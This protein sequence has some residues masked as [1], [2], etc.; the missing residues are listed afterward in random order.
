MICIRCGNDNAVSFRFCSNCGTELGQTCPTCGFEN[1][2]ESKFCGCCGARLQEI[3]GEDAQGERRQLTVLFCDIVGATA[4]SQLLDPE[5]LRE[6]I[7]S[8]QKVCGDAVLA[9]EGHVAQYLGD[10]V[11]MYF[12]Y[13]RSH[14]DEA[15]RA[16]RCGLDILKGVDAVRESGRIL[17]DT[18]LDVRLG[19]HTGRVVVGPVGDR[20]DQIALGDTPNIAARIQSEAEPGTLVV[21]EVTWRIVEGYVTG[22]C[23]G[24]WQL[25]GVSEPMRLWLVTGES[26]SRE[27]V[28]VASMLTSFVGREQERS[29]LGQ[30]WDDSRAGHNRFVLLRGDPG[31]GK[32]R[33]AQLFCEEVQFQ[34]ADLLSMR[35]TPYNTNSPFHPVIELIERRFGL[36]HGQTPTERLERIEEGLA[37]LELA[38]PEAIALLAS[39]L[40]IP[41]GNRYAPL[42]LSPA[43]RRTR[44]MQLLAD[45]IIAITRAGPVLLLVE[46]LH[47]T[48][49]STLEFLQLLVTT[50]A[51]VPLLG[52]FTA[53]CE[54]DVCWDAT[55]AVHR[56]ELPRF[57][58]AEVETMVRSVALGKAL[59]S[60]VLW[61]ITVRS[62]GVP[63]FVEELT[64][65]ILDSGALSERAVSWEA[66]GPVAIEIPA[67]MDASLTSRIDRLGASRATAQ[68]AATIGREFSLELL[69]EVSER[70]EATIRQDLERLLQAGLAWSAE[71]ET[72]QL[73]FKH[74]LVRDAAYNSLLRSTRQR[75]HSRIAAALRERFADETSTRPDLIAGHLTAAGE[76]EDAVTFWEAAGQQA[77]VRT[78]VHEAAKHFQQAI[79]CLQ[80]LP[81]TLERQERELKLQILLAPLLMAVHGWGAVEVEQACTRALGLAQDLGRD[82]LSYAPQWGLWTNHFLRGNL[83]SALETAESVFQMGRSSGMRALEMLGRHA[84]AYTL[85]YMGEFDRTLEETEAGL[86]LYD[87][88]QEKEIANSFGMSSVVCLLACRAHSLWML[89]YVEEADENYD[90]MLQIARELG[91]P[92]SLACALTF[93][94]HGAFRY[95]YI[96]E[97]GR[98]AGIAE[99]LMALVK[100]VD[101][102]FWYVV[103]YTYQGLIA[104]AL[105]EE[106]RA[107]TQMLEGLELFAQTGSRLTLVMMNV[108]CA[109]AFY[110]LGDDDEAFRR[111]EVAEAETARGEG[112]LAPDIWRVRGRL[113]TRQGERSAAEAAY[114]QAIE[115]A[116]AQRALSLELRAALDLYELHAD[117]GR[118]EDGRALLASVLARFTQGFD[119]PE[120]ARASAIVRASP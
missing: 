30:T 88:Q 20:R 109:E 39:L 86:A 71:D 2:V 23:I 79:D 5:D 92:F 101:F 8:C 60:E 116:R 50:A 38:E 28:E 82:D 51:D 11:L 45:F 83:V 12:G 100:E 36:D 95:S 49:T 89:G 75:Y 112:L 19:A 67:T 108:L 57:Q 32:S 74:A 110:R 56:I 77:L 102:F 69:R 46:D 97:M 27:R 52:I 40:S 91:H 7:V 105:G 42:D 76:D 62:D 54:F 93:T 31:M 44:T 68:L 81:A 47:W 94:L 61:Q 96:G 63:L 59:P 73:I 99:E 106:E 29:V 65:S 18:S 87:P 84:L 1:P 34:A 114:Y 6:L 13:P 113:L 43:R 107:R 14:E 26:P 4:L 90:R 10:G 98:L 119:R 24:Q 104:E 48:D 72:D 22:K 35:S 25:K 55:P 80:R 115:R 21:S 64:R 111:L 37:G 9:H 17:P 15:Q 120:L 3:R 118:S 53:R 85:V 33:L 41:L 70:D 66:V 58:R 103:T 117:D 78:A 16:V